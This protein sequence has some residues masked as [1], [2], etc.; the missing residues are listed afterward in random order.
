MNNYFD[1]GYIGK[2]Q[3]YPTAVYQ[4]ANYDPSQNPNK[5]PKIVRDQF[6]NYVQLRNYW[7]QVGYADSLMT[8]AASD[9]NP[10]R[11]KYT[12]NIYDYYDSRGFKIQNM[13]T[14]LIKVGQN[15]KSKPWEKNWQFQARLTDFAG[16]RANVQPLAPR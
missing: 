16:A 8:F 9:K 12:E 2:F 13:N 7:E 6:G 1:Y 11:A 10:L 4:Y 5:E 14:L 15:E 3:S